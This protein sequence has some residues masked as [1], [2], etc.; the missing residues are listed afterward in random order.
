MTRIR[1]HSPMGTVIVA[2]FLSYIVGSIPFGF[3]I[4]KYVK[5]VDIRTVGSKNIGATNVMRTLGKG[6]G[7]TTLVLD[8]LKGFVVVTLLPFL[9]YS[10]SLGMSYTLFQ[11]LCVI[12]VI[13]GHTWTLFLGFKGGK[14]VA[15]STGALFGIAPLVVL[16]SSIVWIVCAKISRYVSLSS[17]V[18]AVAFVV[19][20]FVFGEPVELKIFSVF[21]ALIIIIRHRSNIQRLRVGTEN[22]IG[23]KGGVEK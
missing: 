18:A 13:C 22:K 20:T 12:G 16:F 9:F 11:L 19:G 21:I 1:I 17:M 2:V 7:I 23:Q 15:T 5:G 4:A 8:M 6:P 3:L 10:D 14:G